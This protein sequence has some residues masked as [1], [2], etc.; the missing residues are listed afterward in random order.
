[1]EQRLVL[2]GDRAEVDLRAISQ[3]DDSG[4][5]TGGDHEYKR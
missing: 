5:E 2:G 4:L 1:V 3:L